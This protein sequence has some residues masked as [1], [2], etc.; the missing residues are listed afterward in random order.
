MTRSLNRR[1]FLQSAGLTIAAAALAGC[2]SLASR[3]LANSPGTRPNF[4]FILI[5]DLG[6]MDLGFMGSSYY[7]TPNIDKLAGEGV[8]FSSA[9]TNAPNC[10][11]TRACIMS[12]QY[13]P[14]HG[15][16]TVGSSERGPARLRKLIPIENETTLDP[17]V[18]TIAEALKPAGYVSASIGKWH[19]GKDARSGPE[20]QGFDVSIAGSRRGATRRHFSPYQLEN[21]Q[22]GPEGEY[23]TDRLT[24]EAI[25]FIQNNKDKPFFLYLPHYAVHTP[26]HAK[27]SIIAKYKS[28]Q[29]A[30]GQN[31]PKYAAMVES[32]DEGVGRIMK[33]L[34]QLGL[35]D[36]TAVI[37][38]SDNGG[39]AGITSMEPL[40]G[41]KGMLYEGG[42]RVPLVV[43]WPGK[44]TAGAKCDVPVIG[45]DF[46][47]TIL[48]M[49]GAAR[50]EGHM[51]D[52]ESIVSLLKGRASVKRE[53][54]FWHFPAYLQANYGWKGPWRT[55]P[56]GAV[57]RGDWKL[58]EF[59]EDGK[60]EL[61]NLKN[62]IG[63]SNNLASV[64]P[65]KTAQLH[66]LLQMWRK[67][68]NAPVPTELN[69][70]YRPDK[71][72]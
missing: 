5:D 55:T 43:R 49:A 56:A 53:A 18:V 24:D 7:E 65:G 31:N 2:K 47:P 48:E 14:R 54:I 16:Y 50:P 37:L 21:L 28:K 30:G 26:I 42:V 12:G 64:M 32:V 57:R 1:H 71:K 67:S 62:D 25:K 52:G 39:V 3:P 27:E 58:I 72:Q 51:L 61:Y 45:I 13:G 60:L 9:Y 11:P 20:A 17:K 6:W 29:P 38:F 70:A 46:Y 4:V 15:V 68:V 35:R 8:V 36:T 59:F 41:G 40:R 19:L 33:K 66:H 22:D 10:A 34:D 69:P 23:L 63:E 44:T